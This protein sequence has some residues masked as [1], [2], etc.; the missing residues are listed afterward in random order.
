MKK[1]Y[2]RACNFHYGI[3]SKELVKKK[4]SLPLGGNIYISFDKIEIFSRDKKNINSKI[5]DLKKINSLP[6]LEKKKNF[7]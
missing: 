7:I 5:I 1:Y 2:T 6:S 3:F 4:L